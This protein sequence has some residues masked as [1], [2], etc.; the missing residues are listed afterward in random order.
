MSGGE[1]CK[2]GC[3][4]IADTGTSLM[5]GPTAEVKALNA[6]IGANPLPGGEV[7]NTMTLPV[8]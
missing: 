4:A 6:E 2:G 7:I 5:V 1:Y 3:Q 8:Q